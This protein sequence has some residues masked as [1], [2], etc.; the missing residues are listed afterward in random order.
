MAQHYRISWI[1]SGTGNPDYHLYL[2]DTEEVSETPAARIQGT[3]KGDILVYTF[4]NLPEGGHYFKIFDGPQTE[5]P[6]ILDTFFRAGAGDPTPYSPDLEAPKACIEV[7]E[8]TPEVDEKTRLDRIIDSD[9]D[10]FLTLT[11]KYDRG[12]VARTAYTYTGDIPN[13]ESRYPY[14][15]MLPMPAF[16]ICACGDIEVPE[17]DI[18]PI[19][20]YV[21]YKEDFLYLDGGQALYYRPS[22]LGSRSSSESL[23]MFNAVDER[24]ISVNKNF[25]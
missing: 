4:Y 24:G 1:Q 11:V 25:N 13:Y 10:S 22:D 16:G 2:S 20:A 18:K 9:G 12:V 7:L 19:T 6:T 15:D 8:Y 14:S 21:R 17:Y 5:G 23:N 3:G